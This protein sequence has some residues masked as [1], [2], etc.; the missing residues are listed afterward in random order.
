MEVDSPEDQY[1]PR[2]I[3]ALFADSISDL[4]EPHPATAE[5]PTGIFPQGPRRR[6]CAEIAMVRIE[7][8]ELNPE[9]EETLTEEQRT[10]L[11]QLLEAHRDTFS[12]G[13]ETTPFGEHRIETGA[14][15]PNSST[16]VSHACTQAKVLRKKLTEMLRLGVIEKCDSPWAA[17][18]VMVPKPEGKARICIDFRKMNQ[19]TVPDSYPLPRMDDL[20]HATRA[21]VISTLD[22]QAGYCTAD[23]R[24][25]RRQRE[26]CVRHPLRSLPVQS[27]AVRFAQCPGNLPENH[28]RIPHRN[29]GRHGT[30]LSRRLGD[31]VTK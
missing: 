8:L 23:C 9:E 11:N 19:I 4:Y 31:P 20:L 18:V 15:P 25:A 14:R 29:A 26:D 16:P 10:R 27:N 6:P 28:G 2:F 17:P 1:D 12:V 5:L 30:G 13:G 3:D 21:A 24:E 7:P 22:L